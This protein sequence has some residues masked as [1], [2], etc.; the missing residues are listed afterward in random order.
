MVS[1]EN[2][3]AWI[4][5]SKRIKERKVKLTKVNHFDWCPMRRGLPGILHTLE[6]ESD[7]SKSLCSKLLCKRNEM[8]LGS[9]K[10]SD[11][12]WCTDYGA[13][14][15]NDNF[16]ENRKWKW[17][18]MKLDQNW[19]CRNLSTAFGDLVCIRWPVQ[20]KSFNAQQKS[21]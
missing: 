9:T 20:L 13:R 3:F 4:P 12:V 7:L 6:I 11:F 5:F 19:T 8:I 21:L 16:E 1:K 14:R 15:I 10:D 2:D 17:N 18:K